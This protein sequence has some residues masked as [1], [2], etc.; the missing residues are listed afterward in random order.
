MLCRLA[1]GVQVRRESWGLLFYHPARHKLCF[2]R[3]GDWLS[4]AHFSGS[5]TMEHITED[6]AQRTGASLDNINRLLPKLTQRLAK[7]RMIAD[8]VH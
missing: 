1:P 4:P 8:E 7:S 2:V 3:S 6:I 5:W